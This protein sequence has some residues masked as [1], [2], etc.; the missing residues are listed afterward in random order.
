MFNMHVGLGLDNRNVN[1]SFNSRWLAVL[2]TFAWKMFFILVNRDAIVMPLG[3]RG[4]LIRKEEWKMK[5]AKLLVT[6]YA[7]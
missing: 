4:S 7:W 2:A 3:R 1:T 6:I 5:R